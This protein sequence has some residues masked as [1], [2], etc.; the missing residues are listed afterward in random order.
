VVVMLFWYN[1]LVPVLNSRSLPVPSLTK[2][3]YKEEV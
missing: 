3:L 2:A 1:Q